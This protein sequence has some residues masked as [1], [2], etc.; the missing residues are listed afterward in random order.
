M[1]DIF[2][3]KQDEKYTKIA[4]FRRADQSGPVKKITLLADEKNA[5]K[6]MISNLEYISTDIDDFGYSISDKSKHRV[7]ELMEEIENRLIVD[8][9]NVR[10]EMPLFLLTSRKATFRHKQII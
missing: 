4:I 9:S 6:T 2:L 5:I 3:E 7:N 10:Y 1:I 8:I